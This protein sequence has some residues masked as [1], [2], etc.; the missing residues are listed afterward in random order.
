MDAYLVAISIPGTI[1]GLLT[2]MLAYQL[3][4]A[5]TRAERDV[6]SYHLLVKH[7]TVVFGG[8]GMLLSLCGMIIAST[9]LQWLGGNNVAISKNVLIASAAAWLWIPFA[10]LA[11]IY[12]AALHVDLKFNTAA[13]LAIFPIA[14][15][16]LTTA[17]AH[18][19][20]GI[21]APALGQL[22]G[23]CLAAACL[24]RISSKRE[25][26]P[27]SCSASVHAIFRQAPWALGALLVFV[28]FPVSDA[29]WGSRAGPAVVSYLGYGQRLVVA[30]ASLAAVGATTV[31]YPRLSR[32]AAQGEENNVQSGLHSS[33]RI[34]LILA[35][36]VACVISASIQLS[37]SLL[38]ERGAFDSVDVKHL[39]DLMHGMLFGMVAMSC[40]GIII[41][42]FF[43]L[44]RAKTASRLSIL[45]F[46]L[47]FGSSGIGQHV[48]GGVGISAAYALT[49]WLMFILS[50]FVLRRYQNRIRK[51]RE[52]LC[53]SLQLI[54][55]S[56]VA[57]YAAKATE[58]TT[59][60][61]IVGDDIFSAIAIAT[62]VYS[63][64]L[65]CSFTTGYL[66]QI[67][68]LCGLLRLP[69]KVA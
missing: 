38:F 2:G 24:W 36:P 14:G 20:L 52:G 7:T 33:I 49:W 22:G 51:K 55:M 27:I 29:Y 4:P 32:L 18:K 28:M 65:F 17:L 9:L 23:H 53:F 34:I 43:A 41:K 37:M 60:S 6:G 15:S 47:Y 30:V 12:T 25:T 5:F 58:L 50:L 64:A 8:Y 67:K 63:C 31:M 39:G 45:G 1:V 66:L 57:F 44:G 48:A 62:I 68:E 26:V 19:D 11:T 59:R 69:R 35:A 56:I 3:V 42:T 46:F 16:A 40:M 54:A 21:I 61:Y 10:C 13:I